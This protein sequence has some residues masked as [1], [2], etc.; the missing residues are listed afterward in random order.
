M[1]YIRDNITSIFV[2]QHDFIYLANQTKASIQLYHSS[3]AP[4]NIYTRKFGNE[5]LIN[6]NAIWNPTKIHI[7]KKRRLYICNQEHNITRYSLETF[8]LLETPDKSIYLDVSALHHRPHDLC[9]KEDER[10][11]V[12]YNGDKIGVYTYHGE[13]MNMIQ[14]SIPASY[15]A[16]A[17]S[18]LY[19]YSNEASAFHKYDK[20]G[21]STN[22]I[23]NEY[24]NECL[25]THL[26]EI[27]YIQYV[28]NVGFYI[29][30]KYGK[31][32]LYDLEGYYH[33]GSN[34]MDGVEDS[35]SGRRA[36]YIDRFE[37]EKPIY[38][39]YQESDRYLRKSGMNFVIP[40]HPT[41]HYVPTTNMEVIQFLVSK[42]D[43]YKKLLDGYRLSNQ[44]LQENKEYFIYY[45]DRK[46]HSYDL[47]FILQKKFMLNS[48]DYKNDLFVQKYPQHFLIND[49]KYTY[50]QS[51][52]PFY[53]M[54]FQDYCEA[55]VYQELYQDI[56]KVLVYDDYQN[57]TDRIKLLFHIKDPHIFP[58]VPHG[59]LKAFYNKDQCVL[60]NRALFTK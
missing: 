2:D 5:S 38:Y 26:T 41:S 44:Y 54:V 32:H 48:R 51:L 40:Y 21:I 15:I 36:F 35:M 20:N 46:I 17:N 25:P 1:V 4:L 9:V 7:D 59:E 8:A 47:I 19:T 18:F 34:P 33:D 22:F 56:Q 24:G 39:L 16:Y 13:K 3:G 53:K 37:D 14:L 57:L 45:Q 23:G 60:L 30:D 43:L 31:V 6:P 58:R 10:I 50:H 29:I 12:L 52:R 27:L 55:L 42:K 28:E 11:F 49:Q